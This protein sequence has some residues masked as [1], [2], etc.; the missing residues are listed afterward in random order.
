MPDTNAV[1]VDG[2]DDSRDP[3]DQ[4]EPGPWGNP[5]DGGDTKPI[6]GR[7]DDPNEFA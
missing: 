4:G 6:F 2:V 1:P 3:D 7:G 5:D